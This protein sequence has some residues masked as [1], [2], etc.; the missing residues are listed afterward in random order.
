MRMPCALKVDDMLQ[1]VAEK[2][3][4]YWAMLTEN[5]KFIR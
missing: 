5:G 2:D 1:S 3:L 4:D